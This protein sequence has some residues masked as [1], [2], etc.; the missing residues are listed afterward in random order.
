MTDKLKTY[1]GKDRIYVAVPRAPRISRLWVWNAE[2]GEYQSPPNG[3]CYFAR[4]YKN[5]VR[6]YRFLAS[7]EDARAWQ[8]GEESPTFLEE[9]HRKR[10][11]SGPR[12]GDIINEWRRRRYP[13]LAIGTQLQYD[14]L[15]KLYLDSLS[16]VRIL[17]VTPQRIDQWLDELK[18]PTGKPMK[19]TTRRSFEHELTLLI[20][21]LRYYQEYYDDPEFHFPVKQRHR[22]ATVL[23]QPTRAVVKMDLREEEF[24]KFRERLVTHKEGKCLAV[25]ATVQYYQALRISEAAALYWVDIQL[26]WKEPQNSRIR[27]VR[28]LC[29][30]RVKEQKSFIR[31]GFKNSSSNEGMKDQPMFPE[32]FEALKSLH[33]E[34]AK[35][36]VFQ[37]NGKHLEYRSI[38]SHYDRAFREAELPYTGTHVMRHGGCRRVYNLVP[39]TAVAQQLLGN[40]DLKTTLIY[41]KRHAS[42]LTEVAQKFWEKSRENG[43]NWLQAEDK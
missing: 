14:K 39:D 33:Q 34:G 15:I 28:S 43:C 31:A 17:E 41:A 2:R 25:L 18:S 32:T 40:S 30:P 38:Q 12:F 16:E 36:L 26:D 1:Q 37:V 3:K 19:R 27:I 9:G 7:V 4:R 8:S 35:G 13:H 21:V 11:P 23:R 6:E 29:F 24:V 22:D 42:A 10:R 5:G 20:T